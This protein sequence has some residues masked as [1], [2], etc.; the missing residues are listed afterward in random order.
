MLMETL[1][2]IFSAFK[3]NTSEVRR[4]SNE[5]KT[6]S[7]GC[8]KKEFFKELESPTWDL[9]DDIS[10]KVWYSA[11]SNL[12]KINLGF[13]LFETFPSYYH[14]LVP[15]YDSIRN[16]EIIDPDEK[17]IIWKQFM[18]YLVSNDYYADPV[19][20]VLWVEFFEDESTVREA[21]DGLTNNY[22][23]RE[24]LLRLLEHAGPVPFDLKEPVYNSLLTDLETHQLI[25]NS[26]LYSAYDVFGKIDKTKTLSILAKLNVDTETENYKLLKE[27]LK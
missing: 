8:G 21:W 5:A 3:L 9:F 7:I 11:I 23:N 12:K 14:F 2:E 22:A 26:L 18:N 10:E 16:K 17:E 13:Q 15:F 6:V 4:L 20:Y 19:G 25:F 1:N 24:S 27:K